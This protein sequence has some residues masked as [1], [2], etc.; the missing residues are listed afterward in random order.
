[1]ENTVEQCENESKKSSI[2]LTSDWFTRLT[3][4]TKLERQSSAAALVR[5][6]IEDGERKHGIFEVNSQ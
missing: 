4:I 5:I 2:T 1:M 3:R 6:W